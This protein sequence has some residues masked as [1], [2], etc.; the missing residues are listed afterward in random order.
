MPELIEHKPEKILKIEEIE[1]KAMTNGYN[2][3][4]H[5]Y[6]ITTDQQVIRFGINMDQRC[7]ESTGY[8]MSEDDFSEFIGANLLDIIIVD[9]C[10][11]TAKFNREL[12]YGTDSGGTVF[13][14]FHTG[15][16]VLQ[17]TAYNSHNGHYGH[18]ALIQSRQLT[19]EW[20][21]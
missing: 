13:I 7:C 14:N 19:E 11:N 16:G 17:F 4:L 6:E 21:L 10:R 5:G 15:Q 1:F 2:N 3:Y 9:E 12:P 20:T 18:I 8:F